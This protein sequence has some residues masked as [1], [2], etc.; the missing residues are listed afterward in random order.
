MLQ[1][2]FG[3]KSKRGQYGLGA[4][5]CQAKEILRRLQT[6]GSC[7]SNKESWANGWDT[8]ITEA[9]SIVEDVT[10]VSIAEVLD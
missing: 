2:S 6:V 9:I 1:K 8:A 10:G 7:G 4:A 3:F 5:E